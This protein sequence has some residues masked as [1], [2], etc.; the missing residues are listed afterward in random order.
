MIAERINN[1]HKKLTSNGGSEE[2]GSFGDGE[3]DEHRTFGFVDLSSIFVT[4]YVFLRYLIELNTA[5][6]MTLTIT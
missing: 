5:R 6:A 4:Q 2:I 1:V 3:D